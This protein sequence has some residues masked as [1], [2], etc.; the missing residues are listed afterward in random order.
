[1]SKQRKIENLQKK[2][3]KQKYNAG[4]YPQLKQFERENIAKSEAIGIIEQRIDNDLEE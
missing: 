4:N 1:M 3:L 2:L